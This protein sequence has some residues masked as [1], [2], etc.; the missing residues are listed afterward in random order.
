MYPPAKPWPIFAT[1]NAAHPHSLNNAQFRNLTIHEQQHITGALSEPRAHS[2]LARAKRSQCTS[3]N[4]LTMQQ[5]SKTHSHAEK[6]LKL[7]IFGD[8]TG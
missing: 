5:H 8:A 2:T 6:R 4:D 7:I 1:L 3:F